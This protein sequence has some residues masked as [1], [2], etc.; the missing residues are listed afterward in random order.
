MPTDF[1]FTPDAQQ[2][3]QIEVPYFEEA[4]A[5]FAPYYSSTSTIA[6]AQSEVI[7]ELARLGAGG[8][9]FV[10]GRF[11]ER[12]GYE[13]RFTYGGAPGVIRVA[14][15]PIAKTETERKID[16]VRLQA[17]L[18]VRDWLKAQVTHRVFSPGSDPLIQQLL[19]DERRT[20]AEF[21]RETRA[22]PQPNP[23]EP[24]LIEGGEVVD[25]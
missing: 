20:L 10:A 15:L 2:Q 23:P 7:T 21:V 6:R 19:V 14:G 5:N 13:I 4:R 9:L 24:P 16:Q 22:L 17:L 18:N 1:H 12:Y 8:I 3:E 25:G 11:G